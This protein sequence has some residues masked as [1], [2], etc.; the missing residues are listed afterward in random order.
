MVSTTG[1][2]VSVLPEWRFPNA[3][4]HGHG[5]RNIHDVQE[6]DTGNRLFQEVEKLESLKNLLSNESANWKKKTRN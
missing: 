3:G 6:A 5:A 4:L 2:A 1:T